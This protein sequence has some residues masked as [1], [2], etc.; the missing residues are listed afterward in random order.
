MDIE[1]ESIG[2]AWRSIDNGMQMPVRA[3]AVTAGEPTS[4]EVEWA[5]AEA[6]AT[7]E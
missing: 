1:A 2:A 7:A 3:A 4:E 6:A 5:L